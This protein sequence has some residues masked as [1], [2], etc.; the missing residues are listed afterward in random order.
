MKSFFGGRK[1]Q[2]AD[3]PQQSKQI[4][5]TAVAEQEHFGLER[6]R[7]PPDAEVE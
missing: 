7:N 4:S 1:L 3:A 6:L 5:Q 2:E